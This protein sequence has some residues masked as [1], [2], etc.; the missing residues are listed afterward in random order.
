MGLL[1]RKQVFGMHVEC[2]SDFEIRLEETEKL[3]CANYYS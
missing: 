3:S 2:M 1:N